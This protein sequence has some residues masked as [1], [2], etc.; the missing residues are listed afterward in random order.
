MNPAIG[1]IARCEG[2]RG[3]AIQSKGF[4]DH[5]PVERVLLVMMPKPDCV[6]Y[7]DWYPGANRVAY[8]PVRHELDEV[9]VREWLRGL[10][11]VFTV[12][13]PYDWRVPLWC[14]EMGVKLI[15][16]G[17]PEFVR[18]MSDSSFPHPDAWWWPTGW[19]LDKLP[20][21]KVMPVPMGA[22]QR[23]PVYPPTGKLRLIH[24][25]GKRAYADRNGTDVLPQVVRAIQGDVKLT[26][27]GIDGQLPEFRKVRNVE[28]ELH[29][30][31]VDDR[32]EMYGN[33][34]VLVMPRR[35]GGLC[36][37]AL[38]AASCGLVVMMSDC[39]PNEELATVRVGR[40]RPRALNLACGSVTM[41][42]PHYAAWA[43]AITA[44]AGDRKMLAE[45][46]RAQYDLLPTWDVWRQRYL[47]EMATML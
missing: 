5:M 14:K 21:G 22:P 4:Y 9:K 35:Y 25:V 41:F 20:A 33:A 17:N 37:P 46:L 2:A 39:S 31:G 16:Q 42:D 3:L 19:R 7:P 38:E 1:L 26:V 40:S 29:P 43:D 13:T 45:K 44:L 34:D 8:D 36:L 23:L 47:D 27:Y 11:V 15:V 28:L 32:W 24:V 30:N 6:E 10:D 18:H 12:E